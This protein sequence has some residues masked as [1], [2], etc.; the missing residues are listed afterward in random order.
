MHEPG[1]AISRCIQGQNMLFDEAAK[2]GL[3]AEIASSQ[4]DLIPACRR[5]LQGAAAKRGVV[6][7]SEIDPWRKSPAQATKTLLALDRARVDLPQSDTAQAVLE[8]INTGLTQGYQAAL[9]V[10]RRHLVRLRHTPAAKQA[11][12]AFFARSK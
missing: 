10:E 5:W 2:S 1:D 12:A 6:D 9:A 4:A 7:Y 3:F 11:L 8:A